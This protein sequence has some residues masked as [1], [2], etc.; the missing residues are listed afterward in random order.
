[1]AT[2]Y[3]IVITDNSAYIEVYNYELFKGNGRI[4][5]TL[6]NADTLIIKNC[7]YIKK[8]KAVGSKIEIEIVKNGYIIKKAKETMVATDNYDYRS[9]IDDLS[10]TQTVMEVNFKDK[11]WPDLDKPELLIKINA[12][13][14]KHEHK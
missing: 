6:T 4:N 2:D 7:S 13:Y 14:K 8:E 9:L 1:M 5:F 11:D 3:K 12:E 10:Q